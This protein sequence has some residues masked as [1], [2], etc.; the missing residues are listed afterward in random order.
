MTTVKLAAAALTLVV[1]PATASAQN[2]RNNV[3]LSPTEMF[4]L[5]QQAE[6][7]GDDALAATLYEALTSDPDPELRAEARFRHARLLIR[8]HRLSEAA[9]LLRALLDEKPDA[10]RV[11]IELA[12]VLVQLGDE[13]GAR[14]ELRQAQAGE[15]PPEV[16]QAVDQF[17]NA[18]RSRKPFGASIEVA[19]VPDTNINRATDSA[20]LDT[21]IAPL[22][23]SDDARQTSG[24]G[25]RVAG[26]AYLRTPIGSKLSLVP[27]LSGQGEF[28]RKAQ[29]NDISASGLIGV[30]WAP[31]RERFVLSGGGTYRWFGGDP[32]AT[33]LSA[34]ID[35]RH[36]IGR[37]AQLSVGATAA[38][39][40]YRANDL[41]DGMLWNADIGVERALT[42]NSGASITL[43][44][45]RQTAQDP[46]YSN[47]AGGASLLYYRQVGRTTLFASALARRL[48][49]DARLFLYPERRRD[50]LLRAGLG[51]TLR[52][53]TVRQFA[54]VVRVEYER[55]FSTVGIYD[56]RRVAVTLGVTRAF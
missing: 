40:D 46:G 49:A 43:S 14:R 35:W 54:P 41:Q 26:Q 13:A 32:Y 10:Q 47:A 39:T 7:R 27:R 12:A 11:R 5:A 38:R 45:T 51:A 24:I 33:T 52:S 2:S 19:L 23:L 36:P 15:L 30:E 31:G 20:T 22:E 55:N 56:Y 6:Q 8:Q 18:L 44:G 3:H 9:V 29:F 34:R 1:A 37:R 28:Y 17:A 21:I 42:S 50:W 25:A 4:A 16:A 48:E 53:L